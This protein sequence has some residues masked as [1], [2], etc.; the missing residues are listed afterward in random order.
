MVGEISTMKAGKAVEV[1]ANWV[2]GGPDE[3]SVAGG[4][5]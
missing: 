1:G 5:G 2:S 4:M 3:W